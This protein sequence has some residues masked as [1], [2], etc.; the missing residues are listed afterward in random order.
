M[1]SRGIDAGVAEYDCRIA[2]RAR[3][4]APP[5]GRLRIVFDRA[6]HHVLGTHALAAAAADLME[7]AALAVRNDMHLEELATT[8]HP[9]PTPTEAFGLTVQLALR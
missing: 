3:I 9:H 2:A 1:S 4:E 7:G 5:L 8:I 6:G